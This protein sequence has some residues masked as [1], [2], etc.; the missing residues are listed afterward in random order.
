MTPSRNRVTPFGDVEAFPLRGAFTGNRGIL[1]SGHE[2]VRFHQH[3]SW[4][5]CALEFKDWWHEQWTAHHMTWLF[6][7]DEAVAL[8]AGHRPCALC[9]RADYQRY[10]SA[11]AQASGGRLPSAQEMNRQLHSERIVRGT[12]R[13]RFQT[14]AASELPDGAFV[15][16]DGLPYLL[17]GSS[18]V[19]WTREGYG[20]RRPRPT[21]ALTVITPASSVAVLRAGY[22]AQIDPAATA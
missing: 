14:A 1:H 22:R 5:T 16:L 17:T 13:R 15:E 21:G 12:P 9:R 18:A 20:A 8:A 3:N 6:F 11:W 19:L 7:H 10:R 4:V 2:I